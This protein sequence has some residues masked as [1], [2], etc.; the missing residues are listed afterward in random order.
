[1]TSAQ[2]IPARSRSPTRAHSLALALRGRPSFN[3]NV[4]PS[5]F[6]FAGA[7][8]N[9]NEGGYL[10][11][12]ATTPAATASAQFWWA[13][14]KVLGQN[15]LY[16]CKVQVSRSDAEGVR[17]RTL[18]C[19]SSV[20]I[21]A[22]SFDWDVIDLETLLEATEDTSSQ[23]AGL[24]MP[25]TGAGWSCNN[26]WPSHPTSQQGGFNVYRLF[27]SVEA[28]CNSLLSQFRH[29]YNSEITEHQ[30]SF[31]RKAGA[32]FQSQDGKQGDPLLQRP[33]VGR[34]ARRQLGLGPL[35]AAAHHK[36]PLPPDR[37]STARS[38]R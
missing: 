14:W 7:Y 24:R 35:R 6:K 13:A 25:M 27:Y 30:L 16:G 5:T 11:Q 20:D 2:P 8:I 10:V 9:N 33:G 34:A 1:M 12:R 3:P 36:Q 23:S 37:T 31:A 18:Y 28:S 38:S 19:S 22:G 21:G 15:Q 17:I 29:G 32:E 4:D 26:L